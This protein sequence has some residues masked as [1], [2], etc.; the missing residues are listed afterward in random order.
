MLDDL[1]M[2]V[3]GWHV[4]PDTCELAAGTAEAA[5]QRLADRVV[6]GFHTLDL[7]LTVDP[8]DRVYPHPP[9]DIT[10]AHAMADRVPLSVDARFDGPA[11]LE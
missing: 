9:E 11:G 4:L 5:D 3:A 6:I 1:E 2:L 8:G 10:R 7:D